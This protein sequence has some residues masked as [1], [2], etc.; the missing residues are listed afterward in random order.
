[1][2]EINQMR[3]VFVAGIGL[4]RWGVYPDKECYDFGSE[5]IFKALDDAGMEWKDIQAA[6]C[7]SV[8]QG[9]GSGHQVIKEVGLTGIPIINV[10]NACSS[11]G[12]A[13]RLAFQMVAADIHDVVLALG[14]E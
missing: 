6:F 7:G 5:A 10:E 11:G 3:D 1:M 13:F 12:S 9:T 2:K 8:Y 14:M 4:T